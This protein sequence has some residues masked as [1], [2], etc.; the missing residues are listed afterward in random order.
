[1]RIGELARRANIT[2]SAIRY[3]EKLG[4]LAPPARVAGRREY[5]N[6]ALG[7]LQLILAAQ[8]AG[9][10][11]SETK[12]MIAVLGGSSSAGWWQATAQAKLDEIDATIARLQAARRTLANAIDCACAGDADVCK[13]VAGAARGSSAR[14]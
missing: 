2:A 3:Y 6:E 1:M 8:H 9:F 14:T 13:L 4:L 12:A 11:L 7:A 5:G 10:T